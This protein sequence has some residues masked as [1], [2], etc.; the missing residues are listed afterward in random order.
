MGE[1]FYVKF[2]DPKPMHITASIFEI[3]CRKKT[4]RHTNGGKKTHPYGRRG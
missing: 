3:S 1:H 4:D 2:G